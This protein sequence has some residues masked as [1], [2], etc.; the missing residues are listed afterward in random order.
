MTAPG[1]FSSNDVLTA[2]DMNDLP[3]GIVDVSRTATGGTILVGTTTVDLG[4]SITF[5]A[6]ANRYYRA[7]GMV[8]V[9]DRNTA[10][11][12]VMEMNLDGAAVQN[13][14]TYSNGSGYYGHIAGFYVFSTTAGSHT[15][16]LRGFTN[17]GTATVF[18]GSA[19]RVSLV[20]ED[21]GPV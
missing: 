4:P 8:A 6:Q 13:V 16:K 2:A 10:G 20:L 9:V 17:T 15:I 18:N 11:W 7:S 5:T 21:M 12:L 14:Y 3:A 1:D 19:E